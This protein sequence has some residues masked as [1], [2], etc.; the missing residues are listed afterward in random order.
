MGM[1]DARPENI[2]HFF[3]P[4]PHKVTSVDIDLEGLGWPVQ[5]YPFSMSKAK[6]MD[7]SRC[8]S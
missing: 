6:V 1:L 2:P 3:I 5:H 4:S 8:L 7:Q